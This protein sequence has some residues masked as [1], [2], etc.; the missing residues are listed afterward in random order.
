MKFAVIGGD[1]RFV[2]LCE[3]LAEDGHEVH[4][5]AIEKQKI[6]GAAHM[7]KPKDA[8]AGAD[9]VIL[10][11]PINA[12]DKIL[13]APLS[14]EI[15][16]LGKIFAA[17]ERG[18]LVCGGKI[19]LEIEKDA[20]EFEI[21]LV[22]YLKREE[23]AVANAGLAA[24]GALQIVMTETGVSLKRAK[25]LVLGF[26]RLGKLVCLKLSAMGADVYAAARSCEAKAWIK[27]LGYNWVELDTVEKTV[28][29]MDVIINTVPVR[30]MTEEKLGKINRRTLCIDLASK[31][32]GMDFTAASRLGLNII[33]ALSLPGEVAPI[34][35]GEIIRDTV[36][37]IIKEKEKREIL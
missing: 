36:Y 21:E 7:A 28:G 24:E 14:G 34:T 32:G 15:H 25:C 19:P 35:S 1:M 8:M 13:N 22:D 16:T 26:G 2:K 6:H 33:W 27:E 18:Q 10:P 23:M 30:I 4:A 5:F 31:P 20:A 37:N 3:M 9:C 11:V 12:R 29:E 17:A